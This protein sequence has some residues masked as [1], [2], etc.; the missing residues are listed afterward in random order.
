MT[1]LQMGDEWNLS[2][3]LKAI[4]FM[5]LELRD[6]LLPRVRYKSHKSPITMLYSN[7]DSIPLPLYIHICM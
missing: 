5:L 1:S 6:R 3:K 2:A 7:T 4:E